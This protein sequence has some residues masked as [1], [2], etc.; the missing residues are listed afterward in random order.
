MSE[1]EKGTTVTTNSPAPKKAGRPKG[2]KNKKTSAKKKPAVKQAPR[3]KRK[4]KTRDLSK[5]TRFAKSLKGAS[6]KVLKAHALLCG[7]TLTQVKGWLK[8]RKPVYPSLPAQRLIVMYHIDSGQ[9]K[10]VTAD[11]VKDLTYRCTAKEV[12]KL[13]S[14]PADTADADKEKAA[15]Q[16][17][18]RGMLTTLQAV[19]T[20]L[21]TSDAD[22]FQV[23]SLLRDSGVPVA[24]AMKLAPSLQ[25]KEEPETPNPEEVSY[26][27]DPATPKGC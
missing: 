20:F 17:E 10:R 16:E 15:M 9:S 21:V 13:V 7:Y 22:T 6:D 14:P 5:F 23:F 24:Q 11:S 3:S 27:S 26:A 1:E 19:S 18:Y 25:T 8:A 12:F 2:S 4:S